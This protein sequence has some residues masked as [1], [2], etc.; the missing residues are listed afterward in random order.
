M[1]KKIR[2]FNPV[3]LGLF[4]VT[5]LLLLLFFIYFAGKFSFILGGGYRVFIEYDFLDNLQVG[6][7][8]RVSGGP[9]IGYVR[10]INFETGKIVVEVMIEGKYKINRDANFSIY[11]TSLVGQKYINIS[12]YKAGSTNFLTNNE[13]VIGITPMGFARTIEFA[14]A[15]L[16]TLFFSESEESLKKL[17]TIFRNISELIQNLNS[18]VKDN[19]YE[20]SSSIQRLNSVLKISVDI[21]NRLNNSVSNIEA[22]SKKLN[23]AIQ[24]IDEKEIVQIMTNI[25]ILSEELKNLSVELNRLSYDKN[26]ILNV[27][28]DKEFKN[29]FDNIVKNVEEFS[30]KIKDNPSI[31]FFGK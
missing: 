20:I 21:A 2:K 4:L 30:K 5:G 8:I 24:N 13:Y 31:L 15:G 27:A 14:G 6:A 16:K 3:S 10:S 11:S 25:Q 7:K 26:S 22:G 12:E 23:S 28:R 9:A 1:F 29:R 19:S 18:L 17:Q